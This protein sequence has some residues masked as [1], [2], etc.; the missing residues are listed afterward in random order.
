MLRN[1]GAILKRGIMKVKDIL[2]L[3]CD[4]LEEENV[5]SY[6]NGQTANDEDS[7]IKDCEL[8]L[9]CYN[10]MTDEISREYYR[11]K[12]VETFTPE[13]GVIDFIRVK[14]VFGGT[15]IIGFKSCDQGREKFQGTSLDYVWFDELNHL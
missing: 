12:T 14:N 2:I 1:S 15:S 13:N 8:L 9:N 3:C 10:L 4:L 6:L 11:F 5:K 7:A